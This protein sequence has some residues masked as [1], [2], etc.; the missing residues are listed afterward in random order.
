[1]RELSSNKKSFVK[2]EGNSDNS[3]IYVYF[4]HLFFAFLVLAGLK[5]EDFF[6]DVLIRASQA[7]LNLANSST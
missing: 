3:N 1:V 7:K 6:K 5:K 2:G 4:I